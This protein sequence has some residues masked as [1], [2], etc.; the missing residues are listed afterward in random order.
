MKIY[1]K[2]N[3]NKNDGLYYLI[4]HLPYLKCYLDVN[5]WSVDENNTFTYIKNGVSNSINLDEGCFIYI[6]GELVWSLR[7]PTIWDFL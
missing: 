5:D 1:N 7:S 2:G 6:N 4:L 3:R